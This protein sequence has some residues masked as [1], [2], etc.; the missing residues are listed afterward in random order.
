MSYGEGSVSSNGWRARNQSLA[1]ASNG[2]TPLVV[3]KIS[4]MTRKSSP[5]LQS[6]IPAEMLAIMPHMSGAELAIEAFDEA[7]RS[8]SWFEDLA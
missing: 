5:V 4:C 6:D 3:G 2:Q 1:S 7:G 8:L